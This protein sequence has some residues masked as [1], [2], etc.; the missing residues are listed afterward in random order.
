MKETVGDVMSISGCFPSSLLQVGTPQE[1]RELTKKMCAIL[2]KGGGFVMG[3]NSSMDECNP[4]LVKV[5]C[6]ATKEYGAC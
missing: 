2:G 6:D 4:D 1:V 5:W 3:A